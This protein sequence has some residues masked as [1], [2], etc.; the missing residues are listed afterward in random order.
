VVVHFW[1]RMFGISNSFTDDF[2]RFGHS[3][4]FLFRGLSKE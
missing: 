4:I 1:K 3:F 2:Q